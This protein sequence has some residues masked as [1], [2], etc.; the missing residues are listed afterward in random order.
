LVICKETFSYPFNFLVR[1]WIKEGNT[2]AAFFFNPCETKYEKC[3]LNEITY[4]SFKEIEGLKI[5]TSDE[6]ADEFTKCLHSKFILDSDYLNSIETRYTHFQNLNNQIVSTQL[7]SRHYHYRNYLQTVDYYQ[8]LNWLTLNYKN[9]EHIVDEFHPDV[10]LDTDN[11]ELARTVMREVCYFRSIPYINIDHPRYEFSK[12]PSYNLN[13]HYSNVFEDLY[14][15][16]LTADVEELSESIDYVNGFRQKSSIMHEMYKGGITAQYKPDAI[17]RSIRI[18]LYMARYFY[19][20]DSAGNNRK[21]KKSNKLIY[22][23]SKEYVK[24][25]FN[26]EIRKQ[27]LMRKNRY[28]HNPEDVKY[29]YMPLH[30]IPESTTFSVSPMY[31]NELTI[32]EAVSKSLPAGWWLYVKEHQ[33]MVGERG[34]DF[35]KK[36]NR[37]PNVRMVQLNYYQDPKPWI[38]KSEGV[39]TISGT[40]AYEAAL[41]GKHAILF[42]DTLFSVIDGVE[43]VYSYE[44]LPEALKDFSK[45]LDNIKSCAAYIETVKKLGYNFDIHTLLNKG[46][47]ILRGQCELDDDYQ[48]NLDQ[49]EALFVDGYSLYSQIKQ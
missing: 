46:E 43:R 2:V 5:Y 24:F 41:L 23:D 25:Y 45:P 31:V 21:L 44:K 7:L 49:L 34:I 22:P 19:N 47:K 27:V 6:I 29:V 18:V 39:V 16:Y 36:V 28:F 42:A 10:V 26:H 20:Q 11:A 33:A 8:Q 40:T 1:K 37:L 14:R 9:V 48:R 4:Y 17:G 30:L 12:L 35:Y 13:L 38:T 15:K 3:T 32:I